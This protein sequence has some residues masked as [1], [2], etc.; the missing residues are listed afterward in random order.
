MSNPDE[1]AGVL[2]VSCDFLLAQLALWF[3]DFLWPFVDVCLKSKI[4]LNQRDLVFL[5]STKFSRL[6][7]DDCTIIGILQLHNIINVKPLFEK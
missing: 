5:F 3:V 4:A 7:C 1:I 2:K 6:V